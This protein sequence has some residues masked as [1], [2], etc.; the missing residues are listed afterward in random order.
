MKLPTLL[1]ALIPAC[2][3]IDGANPLDVTTTSQRAPQSLHTALPQ[4]QSAQLFLPSP[5][6]VAPAPMLGGVGANSN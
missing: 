1:L 6:P 2:A 4:P 5:D 3:P